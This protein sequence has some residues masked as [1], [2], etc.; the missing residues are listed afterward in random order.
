MRRNQLDRVDELYQVC[1]DVFAKYEDDMENLAKNVLK[2]LKEEMKDKKFPTWGD[3]K[4]MLLVS[5]RITALIK[6]H[7]EI[8]FRLGLL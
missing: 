1:E 4:A 5:D 3:S 2:K 7:F 8:F 6:G